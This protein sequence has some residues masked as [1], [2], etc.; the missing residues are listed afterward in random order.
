MFLRYFILGQLSFDHACVCFFR[1]FF[2][3][4]PSFLPFLEANK[5]LNRIAL[6]LAF[7]A[8]VR[9]QKDCLSIQRHAVFQARV[10]VSNVYHSFTVEFSFHFHRHSLPFVAATAQ[11]HQYR[12]R[13]VSLFAQSVAEQNYKNTRA[14]TKIAYNVET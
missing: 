5:F 1:F 6:Y 3:I 10:C 12:L 4:I 9:N 11:I 8:Q 2:Q 14:C 7:L 13:A